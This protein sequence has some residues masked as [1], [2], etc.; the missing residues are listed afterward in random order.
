MLDGQSAKGVTVSATSKSGK[1]EVTKTDN[2]GAFRIRGKKKKE[3][4]KEKIQKRKKIQKV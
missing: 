4:E 3:K 2:N 1:T